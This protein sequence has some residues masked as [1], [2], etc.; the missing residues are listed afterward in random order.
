MLI[1]KKHSTKCSFSVDAGQEEGTV[2]K[3]NK[4]KQNRENTVS[5]FKE[6]TLTERIKT[7]NSKIVN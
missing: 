1:Q 4:T 7:N 3:Q 6:L 2:R 5:T